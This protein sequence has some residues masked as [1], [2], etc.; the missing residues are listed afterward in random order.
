MQSLVSGSFD[1]AFGEHAMG[2]EVSA[3]SS[4]AN[5]NDSQRNYVST[6]GNT[7]TGKSSMEV[8]GG[9]NNTAIG[10]GALQGNSSTVS[11]GGTAT[12][13]DTISLTFTGTYSGSPQTT[14]PITVTSN[15]TSTQI[16]SALLASI[17]ANS[18]LNS[19]MGTG[20]QSSGSQISLFWQGT[21]TTGQSI[22][23]TSTIT[24]SATETVAVS[25]GATGANNIALGQ[26]AIPGVYGLSTGGNNLGAGQ[27]TL[28]SLSTGSF[29]VAIDNAAL[30]SLTTASGAVGIGLNAGAT[31]TTNPGTYVGSG[32]GQY[33]TGGGNVASG[34][35][36]LQGA[37]AGSTAQNNAAYGN[38]ALQAVT[39][40][41]QNFAGGGSAGILCTTCQHQTLVGFDA[42]DK[43]TT[44]DKSTLIGFSA[45]GTTYQSGFGVILLCSGNFTCDTPAANTHD[46]ISIDGAIV[47]NTQAPTIASGFGTGATVPVGAS[48]FLFE[49][50][51][52]TGGTASSGVITMPTPAAPNAWGCHV[53][54]VT[55]SATSNTVVTPSG[56]GTTVTLTN[57]SRTTGALTAWA[58]SDVLLVGPCGAV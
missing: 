45:G 37:S 13:G 34:L 55:N 28:A 36:A 23:T 40:A 54:D 12:A 4:T 30:T 35:D 50:N 1:T 29:N 46:Y 53:V 25:G 58:A 41:Q 14:T 2:Y 20:S 17:V 32:A 8:G 44:A 19:V 48:T 52:G 7:S 21:A 6:G 33:P 47:E 57:Y 51:V 10:F 24:G 15:E 39:T 42:G 56:A 26:G 22:V 27:N 38:L 11:V 18:T 3:N 43:V 31:T 5:G 49:V 16:A 9:A